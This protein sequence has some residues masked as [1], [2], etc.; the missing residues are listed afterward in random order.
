MPQSKKKPKPVAI[1]QE[2]KAYNPTK[3][4]V[5]KFIIL[6]LALGFVASILIAAV[7]LMVDYF[8]SL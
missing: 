7:M 8:G 2:I 1:E 3:S 5:G 6:I 4:K